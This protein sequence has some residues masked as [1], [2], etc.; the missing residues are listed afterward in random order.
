MIELLG[1]AWE[2][3][4]SLTERAAESFPGCGMLGIDL[5]VRPGGKKFAL[6]EANAFGDNLP[7][8]LFNGQSTY[9]AELHAWRP[10]L[11]ESA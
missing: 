1:E 5:L 6:L 3:A 2:Q 10:A 11:K 7:G 4:R 9:E 8:L